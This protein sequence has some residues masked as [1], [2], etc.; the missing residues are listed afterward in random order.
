MKVK[1]NKNHG[2]IVLYVFLS[3]LEEYNNDG[4][5]RYTWR[6]RQH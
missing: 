2:I 3:P 4:E 1:K 5:R 6:Q